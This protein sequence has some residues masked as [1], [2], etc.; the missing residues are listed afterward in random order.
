MT[1]LREMVLARQLLQ[2][3]SRTARPSDIAQVRAGLALHINAAIDALTAAVTAELPG[4]VR[5]DALKTSRAAAE[6]VAV[7]T[8]SQRARIVVTIGQMGKATD[9]QLQTRL[10]IGPSSERPRR[11]ELVD[12]GYVMPLNEVREHAGRK[13]TVWALTP[14]G[15][16]LCRILSADQRNAAPTVALAPSVQMTLI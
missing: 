6:G 8:G 15:L 14:S 9:R 5:T 11:G 10:G 16:E 1:A 4:K 7:R 12:A 13:W 3:L 2:D